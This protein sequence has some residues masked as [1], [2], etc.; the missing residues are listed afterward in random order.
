MLKAETVSSHFQ[1]FAI[2]FPFIGI[3]LGT[4]V[5]E[6]GSGIGLPMIGG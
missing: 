1:R 6:P 5:D 3:G 2:Y 4:T